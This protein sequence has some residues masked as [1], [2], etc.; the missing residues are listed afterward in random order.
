M[1]ATGNI[2]NFTTVDGAPDA[3]WFI[4][5]MDAANAQ[6]EYRDINAD[7]AAALGDLSG[8]TVLEVGCGTGDDA[9]EIAGLVGPTGKVV[10]IDVSSTMI[11]EARRRSAGADLPIDFRIADLVAGL[12]VPDGTFD[13]AWAKLVLMHTVDIEAA[14]DELVRV[15]RPG[16]R[17]AVYDIDFETTIV[18]HPDM[19]V[20]REVMRCYSDG[21]RNNWS[22][23]QLYRRMKKRNLTDV[24]VSPT[25]VVMTFDFFHT[26][27]AGRLKSAQ[28]S[29]QLALTDTELKDWWQP[30]AAAHDEGQ[31]FSAFTG[32]AVGAT[33]P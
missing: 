19:A 20:T 7:L 5:F 22:G 31:F 32:F 3:S 8:K 25:T 11:D 33:K 24:T 29:G 21:P 13:G 4:D 17:I 28:E 10:A 14:I 16:G 18:D 1:T 6:P 9:R 30:L 27:V 15:L 12:D 2:K 23:R 26:L